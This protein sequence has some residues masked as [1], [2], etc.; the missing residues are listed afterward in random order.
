MGKKAAI[1]TLNGYFNYGN[2]LQ[3]YALQ[4]SIKS[5]GFEVETIIYNGKKNK[6]ARTKSINDRITDLREKSVLE[7]I[8]KAYFKL[9]DFINKKDLAE[10][11]RVRTE[12]FKKFTYDYIIET[13]Y[14]LSEENIP[15]KLI[16]AYK[17]FITGS[18][19]V[20]NPG[21][22]TGSSVYFLSFAPKEKRIAYAPSFGV[23]KIND[24]HI[25]DY[26]KWLAGIDKLS[27]RE[28]DGAEIIKD[29]VGAEAPVLVDPTMLLTVKQWAEIESDQKKQLDRRY[30]LT[31]FLGSIPKEYYKEIKRIASK[32]DLE[33]INLG[34]SRNSETYRTGPSEF[35][36]YIKYCSL[37]CTDSFHGT[38]F[39][40]IYNK[41]F[42]VYERAGAMS[43]YS[44]INTLLDKFKLNSRKVEN[45]DFDKDVFEI[46]Y[47]HVTPILEVERQK[48]FD[49]LRNSLS[50]KDE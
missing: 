38:V 10:S 45:I 48:G 20:W 7:I 44:R 40:I 49:F 15:K 32:N 41:P 46:D 5:L 24:E 37:F 6:V 47:S 2:R 50:V 9:W 43:M 33:I 34:D 21:Y 12:I 14:E 17:Y 11:R 13:D 27:V 16:N 39:S 8:N 3:N 31:Y 1:V 19:Q 30:I 28:F 23:S 4:E 35:L 29:L 36:S 25:M 26:K 18:D 22:N 42:I